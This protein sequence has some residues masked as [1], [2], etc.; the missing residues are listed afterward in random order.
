MVRRR[1]GDGG[2]ETERVIGRG[3]RREGEGGMR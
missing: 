1:E 3:R 2:R